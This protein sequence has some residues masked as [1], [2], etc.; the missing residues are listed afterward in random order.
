[1]TGSGTLRTLKSLKAIS[2]TP[3]ILRVSGRLVVICCLVLDGGE[4]TCHGGV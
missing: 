1:M 2:S 4:R 3:V